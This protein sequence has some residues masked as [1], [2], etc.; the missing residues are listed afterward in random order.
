[1]AITPITE[2]STFRAWYEV[3]NQ[4]IGNLNANVVFNGATVLGKYK[5]GYDA[6]VSNT[7]LD[8][9]NSFFVDP[10][11]VVLKSNTTFAANVVAN[12]T[13]GVFTIG[14]ANLVLSPVNGTRVDTLAVFNANTTV[15]AA[16]TVNG[17]FSVNGTF[18]LTGNPTVT[19]NLAANGVITTRQ[20]VFASNGAVVANTLSATAYDNFT[21]DGLANC[22]V[23]SLTP[24]GDTTITGIVAPTNLGS[25]GARLLHIQNISDT[26][27]ITLVA[28][29]SSEVGNRFK[30]PGS[31]NVGMAPGCALSL[32]YTEGIDQ[33]R[34]LAP[35]ISQGGS[36][37]FTG[38]VT[39]TGNLQVNGT[40]TGNTNGA[41]SGVLYTDKT[42][43]RVGIGKNNPGHQLETTANA[44]IGNQLIAPTV[45]A[46][47]IAYAPT[48]NFG[49]GVV[50]ANATGLI[51]T[52]YVSGNS[53]TSFLRTLNAN[54]VTV[55][56]SVGTAN[57]DV[58]GHATLVTLGLSGNTNWFAGGITA[59]TGNTLFVANT[60]TANGSPNSYIRTLKSGTIYCDGTI[61]ATTLTTSTANAS[62]NSTIS[63]ITFTANDSCK[64]I[65]TTS[66]VLWLYPFTSIAL[67][68]N[69]TVHYKMTFIGSDVGRLVIPVG[70]NYYAT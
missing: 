32:I 67:V 37:S 60:F 34:V 62:A 65:G 5:I 49:G 21:V 53:G 42:N 28:N 12:S 4:I 68:S 54:V 41:F 15:N 45:N 26:Y 64:A 66:G 40:T 29:Q 17:S 55:A 36:Q 58:S 61:N 33:W 57:L 63:G 50:V 70:P 1:M 22:T 20:I 38:D 6:N 10:A 2:S 23:L 48:G 31:A 16:L 13:V 46:T 27:T 14:A 44:Y 47:T 52:G 35:Q 59:N 30:T 3:T 51:T 24:Q 39:I 25:L 7:W 9:A 11:N 56:N 8:V 43:L 69:T 18:N 19:G